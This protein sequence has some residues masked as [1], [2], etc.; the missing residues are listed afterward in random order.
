MFYRYAVGEPYD[1]KIKSWPP[2]VSVFQFTTGGMGLAGFL[3]NPTPNEIRDW[4]T[5]RAQFALFAE[6]DVIMILYKIGASPWSDAPWTAHLVPPDDRP[7]TG[8]L[9]TK[10]TRHLLQLTL[11]NSDDGII[12]VFRATS[13]SPDF[14]RAL[15]SAV[16]N[17]LFRPWPGKAEYNVQVDHIYARYPH[18]SNM[19]TDA[20]V[21]C[22]GGD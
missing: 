4:K 20:I 6:A 12:K 5:G 15:N 3:S 17:Q 16:Q 8:P 19:L 21:Q 11:V 22:V 14:S 9:P 10:E 2:D 13:L 1:P 7:D 18:P